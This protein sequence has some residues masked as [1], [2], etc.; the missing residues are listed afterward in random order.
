MMRRTSSSSTGINKHSLITEL[1]KYGDIKP[2]TIQ[3]L[4]QQVDK[5]KSQIDEL[6]TYKKDLEDQNQ[7][8]LSILA[9]SEPVVEFFKSNR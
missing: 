9:H 8:M 1:Q 7:S 2:T 4:N 3:E 6:Q 5:L